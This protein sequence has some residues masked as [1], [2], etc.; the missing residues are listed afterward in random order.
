[1]PQTAASLGLRYNSPKYWFAGF[2]A[3]YFADIYIDVNPDRRTQEAVE[4]FVVTDPQ[5][6]LLI[7]QTK[8]PNQFT[9]DVFAGKSWRVKKKY[10]LNLN[11][12]ISNITNN[13]SFATGGFEQLRYNSQ[14]INRFPPK[15]SYLYVTTYFLMLN[16]RY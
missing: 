14:D 1:M 9:V 2:N 3:N 16:W 7:D 4:G 12:N 5:W 10:F 13:R 15:V 8:L 11:L 6:S